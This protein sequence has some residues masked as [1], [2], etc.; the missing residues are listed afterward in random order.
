MLEDKAKQRKQDEEWAHIR[1]DHY[2]S[3]LIGPCVPNHD[4]PLSCLWPI[5]AFT[6]LTVAPNPH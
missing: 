4:Q 6:I 3:F 5:L 1:E 2:L